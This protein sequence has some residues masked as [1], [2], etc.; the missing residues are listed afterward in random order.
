MLFCCLYG[1]MRIL[2]FCE[3]LHDRSRHADR[4]D[5]R[6]QVARRLTQLHARQTEEMRQNE[7]ERNEE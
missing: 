5:E 7:R 4:Q 3:L 6:A 1:I 2:S